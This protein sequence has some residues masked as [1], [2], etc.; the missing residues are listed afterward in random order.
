[1]MDGITPNQLAG[2]S[3][4]WRIPLT[5]VVPFSGVSDVDMG[6]MRNDLVHESV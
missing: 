1:M 5:Y 6:V 2:N 4:V 3:E